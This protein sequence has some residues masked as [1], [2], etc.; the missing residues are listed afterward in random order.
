MSCH[1]LI[2]QIRHENAGE[3]LKKQNNSTR[4]YKH[5]DA[6]QLEEVDHF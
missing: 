4:Y 5:I 3:Q 1:S 2:E 6:V